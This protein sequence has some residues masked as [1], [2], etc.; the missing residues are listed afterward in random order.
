MKRLLAVFALILACASTAAAQSGGV[1][2]PICHQ[3]GQNRVRLIWINQSAVPA[4]TGHGDQGLQTFYQDADGDGFGDPS[5]STE[6]CG[7]PAG[8]VSNSDDCNDAVSGKACGQQD[9]FAWEVST[10]N[11]NSW[12]PVTLPDANWGCAFCT[13]FYRTT[14]TGTPTSVTFRWA[15]DNEARM[16]VN[17]TVAYDDYYVNGV[18]WCTQQPC[19]TQCGD[20]YSNALNVVANQTPISLDG[21]GLANFTAGTNQITWQVN[22][23]VG[24]TGFYTVMSITY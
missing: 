1:R 5:N 18:D 7:Q 23:Q 11:G 9:V 12:Y 3:D 13:R 22:Q 17:G 16:F 19:C 4:H 6:A 10:D 21:D 14:F 8:Y 2:V 24:G 15:S 20:T